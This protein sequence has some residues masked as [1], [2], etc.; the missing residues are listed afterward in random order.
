MSFVA[1]ISVFC[2]PLLV[3]SAS[4]SLGAEEAWPQLEGPYLGQRPPG[5]TPEVFATGL[6]S[7]DDEYELNSVFSLDGQRVLLRDLHDFPGG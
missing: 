1:L 6:I 7:T 2:G 3:L 4:R 5:L